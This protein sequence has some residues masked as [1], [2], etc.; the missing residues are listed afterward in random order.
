MA[1]KL[2][3]GARFELGTPGAAKTVTAISN[4]TEGVVNALAHGFTAGSAVIMSSGWDLIDGSIYEVGT[5]PAADNFKLAATNTT[6]TVLFPAGQGAGTATPVTAW[7][8]VPNVLAFSLTGGESENTE[9]DLLDA[10]RKLQLPSGYSALAASV[11][12]ADD[13]S[14]PHYAQLKAAALKGGQLPFRLVLKSGAK[15][16][17]FGY[18][19]FSGI[20]TVEKGNVMANKLDVAIAGDPTRY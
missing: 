16:Y 15:I 1:I 6:D 10:S 4:A 7:A 11:S 18:V 5:A 8:R 2:P 13:N 19:S 17:F 14:L 12:I 3:D 20:P 9:V